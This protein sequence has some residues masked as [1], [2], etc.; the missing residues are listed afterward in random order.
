MGLFVYLCGKMKNNDISSTCF[1]IADGH[2]FGGPRRFDWFA[3]AHRLRLGV[4]AFRGLFAFDWLDCDTMHPKAPRHE[5]QMGLLRCLNWFY[6]V[7]FGL[8]IGARTGTRMFRPF[9]VVLP[10]FELK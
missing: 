4:F 10:I 5:S 7:I 8:S 6:C 2:F 1:W 3:Q 9:A